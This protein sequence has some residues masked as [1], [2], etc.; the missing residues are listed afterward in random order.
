[1]V[2]I[3]ITTIIITVIQIPEIKHKEID[4]SE[5]EGDLVQ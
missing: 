5:S 3:T 4:Q 2:I 1:M